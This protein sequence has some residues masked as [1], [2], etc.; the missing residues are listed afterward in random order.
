VTMRPA[1]MLPEIMLQ[2]IMRRASTPLGTMRRASIAHAT[3]R[4]AI[5]A[6]G[7]SFRGDRRPTRSVP[8][9]PP[10][11]PRAPAAGRRVRADVVRSSARRV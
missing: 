3:T 1:H 10:S 8:P 7:R 11:R 6:R 2:G 5:T 4:L 9:P